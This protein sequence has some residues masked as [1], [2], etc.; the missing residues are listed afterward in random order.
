[1]QQRAKDVPAAGLRPRLAMMACVFWLQGLEPWRKCHARR[2]KRDHICRY[3]PARETVRELVEL[4]RDVRRHNI[5]IVATLCISDDLEQVHECGARRR[6]LVDDVLDATVVDRAAQDGVS[7][8]M[9]VL[10]ADVGDR[11][12]LLPLDV[13]LCDDGGGWI[14]PLPVDGPAQLV[15]PA[16]GGGVRARAARSV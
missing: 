13:L 3:L 6:E 9:S 12:Q 8:E 14:P 15:A 5:K 11:E 4:T 1:L 16:E 2:Q 7:E 10:R